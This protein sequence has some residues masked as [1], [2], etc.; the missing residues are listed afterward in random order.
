MVKAANL[1]GYVNFVFSLSTKNMSCKNLE[2]HSFNKS[3][4]FGATQA[5]FHCTTCKI[6]TSCVH[7]QT[8]INKS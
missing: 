3:Y 7:D 6:N 8:T 2:S 5:F 4:S 1:Y